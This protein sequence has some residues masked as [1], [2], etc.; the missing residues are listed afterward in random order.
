MTSLPDLPPSGAMIG[1]WSVDRYSDVLRWKFLGGAI[2]LLVITLLRFAS[3]LIFLGQL[4]LFIV[5]AWELSRRNV[6]RIETLTAGAISGVVAAIAIGLGFFIINPTFATVLN[7][8]PRI[9]FTALAG[10][11]LTT[12]AWLV[13]KQFIK[14]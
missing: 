1:R 6:G 14:H 7:I 10:A 8:F 13:N 4:V 11:L 5:V 2:G 9:V 3:P 12:S